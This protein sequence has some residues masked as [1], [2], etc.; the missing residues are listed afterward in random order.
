[1]RSRTFTTGYRG[2]E[3][4]VRRPDFP[5][6]EAI[7]WYLGDKAQDIADTT[8]RTYRAWLGQFCRQLPQG[9]QVL[10]SLNVERVEAFVRRLEEPEHADEQD[11]RATELRPLPDGEAALVRG[12]GRPA[13]IGPTSAQAA[14]ADG[15]RP[16]AVHRC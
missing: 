13:A 3:V 16:R 9:E 15:I 7:G 5:L 10:A 6:A 11:D 12:Y 1:M 2:P 4:Y 8:L 14:A